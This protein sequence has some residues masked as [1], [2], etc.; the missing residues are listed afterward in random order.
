MRSNGNFKLKLSN[1]LRLITKVIT[2][3]IAKLAF[4]FILVYQSPLFEFAYI[5]VLHVPRPNPI[6]G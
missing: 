1:K 3:K 2:P 4:S 5:A 6:L